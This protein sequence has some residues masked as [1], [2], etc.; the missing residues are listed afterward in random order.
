MLKIL[1][2]YPIA[3]SEFFE[4]AGA[5][6]GMSPEQY[7]S[8]NEDNQAVTAISWFG[9][10][11]HLPGNR[12]ETIAF[13]HQIFSDF[14]KAARKYP[15][16]S[17]NLIKEISKMDEK[18]RMKEHPELFNKRLEPTILPSLKDAFNFNL[19]S[20]EIQEKIEHDQF[21]NANINT[22]GEVPF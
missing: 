7:G 8:A 1:E 15:D 10:P 12:N 11:E 20:K 14:D 3:Y 22:S 19:I 6:Y 13:L 9:Y 4:W 17:R 5:N 2:K 16:K 18:Q 21:W